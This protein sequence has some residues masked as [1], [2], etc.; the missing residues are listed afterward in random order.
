[1]KFSYRL[2]VGHQLTEEAWVQL[3]LSKDPPTMPELPAQSVLEGESIQFMVPAPTDVDELTLAA[4]IPPEMSWLQF[5][6]STNTFYG[7]APYQPGS[8]VITVTATDSIGQSVSQN[9]ELTV[10]SVEF[11]PTA[12]NS[13]IISDP[14]VDYTFNISDFRY[15]DLDEDQLTDLVVTSLPEIGELKLNGQPVELGQQIPVADI[16]S[17]QYVAPK[18]VTPPVEQEMRYRNQSKTLFQ[19]APTDYTYGTLPNTEPYDWRNHGATAEYV[20]R[21][22]GWPWLNKGG[23]WIDANGLPQGPSPWFGCTLNAVSGTTKQYRYSV[24][25]T[26]VVNESVANHKWLALLLTATGAGR[27]LAG[28]RHAEPPVL[29]LTT[30]A[31]TVD[32]PCIYS[33]K[34]TLSTVF[35]SSASTTHTLP[36]FLEF[37]R[38]TQQVIRATLSFTIVSHLS[39]SSTLKGFLLTPYV[40][41]KPVEYGIAQPFKLDE[42]LVH[43]ADVLGVHRYVDGSTRSD[44]FADNGLN[45]YAERDYDPALWNRGP[46]DLTKLPHNGLGKWVAAGQQFSVIPSSYQGEGFQPLAPNLGAMK[47]VMPAMPV[48]TGSI[49]GYSGTTASIAKLYIPADEFGLLRRV[50]VRYYIRY[51]TPLDNSFARRFE[52]RNEAGTNSCW[53][54]MGGKIGIT[55]CHDTTYGGVSGS[56]GGGYGWTMRN[57]WSDRNQELGGIMAG[58]TGWGIHTYDY[59]QNN[60][61][62]YRYGGYDQPKDTN[63][64]SIGGLGGTMWPGKWYCVE[65]EVNLNGV[66]LEAPGF[67]PDGE[68]RVWIDGR[69]ALERTKMVMRS[70]PLYSTPYRDGY[71]R[72]CRELGIRDLWFN[73]FHGGKTQNTVDRTLF[74]TGLAWSRTKLGPMTIE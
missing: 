17:L 65:M 9:F 71:I 1:M 58:T 6:T 50:F 35:C 69:L 52:V 5:D 2:A 64:G 22:S 43:H 19:T 73:W 36:A 62:G 70:L 23:D 4:S 33:T 25:V 49:V 11:A 20:C 10:Q 16:P 48:S 30:D 37:E 29:T 18:P 27:V 28:A 14:A 67:I 72:P 42:G 31:G 12:L 53:T 34:S 46:T 32:V 24:D 59:I 60:P 45:I 7:R 74:V 61:A 39:G 13:T 41:D 55:P 26:A 68:V 57:S 66:M 40:N 54:D 51:G 3:T 8:S 44:F 21:S 56:A 47:V 15:Q 38:P 63:L